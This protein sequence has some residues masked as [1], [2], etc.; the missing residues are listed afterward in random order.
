VSLS[1]RELPD[2]IIEGAKLELAMAV[3]FAVL[4]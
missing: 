2:R 1:D 3:K 4:F